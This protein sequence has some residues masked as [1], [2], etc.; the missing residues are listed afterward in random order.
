MCD[1]AGL[2]SP[3]KGQGRHP[4]LMT[5]TAC[6]PATA[7]CEGGGKGREAIQAN[8]IRG[9]MCC[10]HPV[11]S[12]RYAEAGSGFA[13]SEASAA[14]TTGF[15]TPLLMWAT[16]RSANIFA[17]SFATREDQPNKAQTRALETRT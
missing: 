10:L 6:L 3:I 15:A 13:G 16:P 12:R 17:D 2:F 5:F 4:A 8:V 1:A 14:S 11:S 9:Y 7:R